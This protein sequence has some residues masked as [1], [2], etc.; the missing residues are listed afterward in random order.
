MAAPESR[1][2]IDLALVAQPQ[3]VIPGATIDVK[4]MAF[5]DDGTPQSFSGLDVVLTWDTDALE[6]VDAIRGNPLDWNFQFGLLSDTFLDGLNDD[7]GDGDA[8]FQ[9]ANFTEA[10]AD[11]AGLLVATLRFVGRGF[12]P[13]VQISIVAS[14]G[15]FSVTKVLRPGA[16]DVTGA[17]GGALITQPVLWFPDVTV[18]A[19][20]IVDLIARGSVLDDEVFGVELLVELSPRSGETGTVTFTPATGPADEDIVLLGDPWGGGELTVF[21]TDQ[22]G[23]LRNG[24][25]LDN[26]SAVPR[27]TTFLGDLVALP[28]VVSE[29]ALGTW[30]VKLCIS[31]CGPGD[32]SKWNT[33]DTATHFGALT[34]A[35]LGDGD[36]DNT[37]VIRDF[38]EMQ[39]C[40]TGDVGPVEPPSYSTTPERRC[41]M[42]DF[43]GDGDIDLGD[44][45]AFRVAMTDP[46]S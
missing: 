40:F 39:A 33:V 3:A 16:I 1:G 27:P 7:L 10:T 29:D 8:L 5:S 38:A 2:A 36:G 20:R 41:G 4:L 18:P 23:L 31:E 44:F 24:I 21:D 28:I 22:V 42:Y 30:D 9:A 35:V 43:D 45:G 13:R 26:G 6:L 15:D 37:I 34:V 32:F 46:G 12:A 19:G 14:L 25:A 11:D 17:L